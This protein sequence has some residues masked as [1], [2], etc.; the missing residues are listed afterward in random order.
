MTPDVS[1]FPWFWKPN[2]R[3]LLFLYILCYLF[4]EK[5][6]KTVDR[7]HFIAVDKAILI[8]K[9]F[10]NYV[11]CNIFWILLGERLYVNMSVIITCPQNMD[12]EDILSQQS[13]C[14]KYLNSGQIE[15]RFATGLLSIRGWELHPVSK[16]Y[17]RQFTWKSDICKAF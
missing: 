17:C 2:H 6:S 16:Q 11:L 9:Y 12:A 7:V 4:L 10:P 15:M 5:D 3:I 14:A 8:C 1:N 13:D